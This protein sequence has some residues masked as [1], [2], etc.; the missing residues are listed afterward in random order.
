MTREPTLSKL[1]FGISPCPND[2]FAFHGLLTGAT[3]RHGIDFEFTV[4]DVEEL[5]QRLARGELDGGK[6]SFAQALTLARDFL[7]LPVGA[8]VGFGV[9][10]LLVARPQ[11]VHEPDATSRVLCPGAGTT[12]F[13]LLRTLLPS[14]TN[15]RH[16]HF[17][18]IMP[19]VA[20]GEADF[21]V[22]IHE[23]R[24]TFREHGLACV[25]DLGELWERRTRSPL[26]LGGLLAMRSLRER[27]GADVFARITAAVR[28]SLDHARAHRDAA[29]TTMQRHAQE[30]SPA[31]VWQH[32]DLY[33][34]ELTRDLG[35]TGAAAL[36]AFEAAA[37][38][39]GLLAQHAP[40]LE[41]AT[42]PRQ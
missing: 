28:D 13:L 32:V 41:V 20:R 9:G 31:A 15:V 26:P 27:F 18:S 33:V 30:L 16:V 38:A 34:N 36:R 4:A 12:A 19:A 17:A 10:P 25:A 2:T 35:G 24:F 42:A 6:A 29:F 1:R 11:F 8:A 23:G 3:D 7:V 14:A 22:V 37:R 5:N 39:A 21:G 40:P